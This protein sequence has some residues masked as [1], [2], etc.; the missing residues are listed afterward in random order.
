MPAPTQDQAPSQWAALTDWC[1]T[2]ITLGSG[3]LAFT[4]AFLTPLL[5][6]LSE[7]AYWTLAVSWLLLFGVVFCGILSYMFAIAY[8]RNGSGNGAA[9]FW[10]NAALGVALLATV[11]LLAFGLQTIPVRTW[12]AS[13]AAAEAV[14]RA[15][16]V[17]QRKDETFQ[18]ESVVLNAASGTFDLVLVGTKNKE[19][20]AFVIDPKRQDVNSAKPK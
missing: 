9:V 1:K 4:V 15:P 16:G 14:R 18:V 5:G 17:L 3:L 10:A 8:L 2:I 13:M 6:T 7:V 19:K 20:F 11:G 12:D